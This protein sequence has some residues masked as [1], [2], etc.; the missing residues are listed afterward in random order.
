MVAYSTAFLPG[1]TG[2]EPVAGIEPAPF[3]SPVER[4]Y[5]A[6]H[7]FIEQ[8]AVCSEMPLGYRLDAP[9]HQVLRWQTACVFFYVVHTPEST[10]EIF[11]RN[12]WL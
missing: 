5:G 10:D 2:Q 9:N 7:P 4:A 3:Q 6:P 1:V 12:G 11:P 8:F